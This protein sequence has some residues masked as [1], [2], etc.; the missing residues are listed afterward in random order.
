[1][2]GKTRPSA[3]LATQPVTVRCEDLLAI[4]DRGQQCASSAPA[5]VEDPAVMRATDPRFRPAFRLQDYHG[6]EQHS[7]QR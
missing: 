6:T 3:W 5:V 2:V 7:R 4:Q 1:M